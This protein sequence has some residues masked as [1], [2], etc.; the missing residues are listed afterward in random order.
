MD[1]WGV[2]RQQAFIGWRASS[3]PS[4]TGKEENSDNDGE[5]VNVK[6]EPIYFPD[7]K[8]RKRLSLSQ[9]REVKVESCEKLREVKEEPYGQLIEVKE[10][11][12]GNQ[13]SSKN[14]RKKHDSK[15]RWSSER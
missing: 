7:S 12:A 4:V 6:N 11:Y 3:F 13:S 9:L 8:K 2:H 15:D 1:R 14:K 5:E 10:E